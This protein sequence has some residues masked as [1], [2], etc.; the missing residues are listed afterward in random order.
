MTHQKPPFDSESEY[1]DITGIPRIDPIP[2]PIHEHSTKP[3][4][5]SWFTF[6]DIPCHKWAARLQEFAAWID[7]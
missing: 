6:D 2:P 3:S 5:A 4:S 1:A 7:L